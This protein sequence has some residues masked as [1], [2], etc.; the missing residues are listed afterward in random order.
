MASVFRTGAED[1]SNRTARRVNVRVFV[2]VIGLHVF[3]AFIM[4][5]FFL[6]GRNG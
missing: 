6:G 1:G 2:Y 3:A 5:L 4:L